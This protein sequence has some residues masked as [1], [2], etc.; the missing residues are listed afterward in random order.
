MLSRAVAALAVSVSF[1][2]SVVE[3]LVLQK[4]IGESSVVVI[5]QY[6]AQHHLIQHHLAQRNL[7]SV[8]INTVN[9]CQGEHHLAIVAVNTV[10]QCQGEQY[11]AHI[12]LAVLTWPTRPSP[13]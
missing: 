10:N 1:Q 11:L 2:A 3:G 5:S 7:A 8:A 9:Q 4:G 13:V 6:E 12:K